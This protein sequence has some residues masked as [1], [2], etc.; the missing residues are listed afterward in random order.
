MSKAALVTAPQARIRRTQQERSAAMRLRLLDA[1]VDCLHDLGYSGTT[2]IEVAARAGVSRGAQLHHF[3][4]KERLVT[5]AVRHILAKRLQ[6][7]RDAFAS[8]PDGADKPGAALD[9]VWEKLSG[10][11]FYAWLELVVASRTDPALH[12]VVVEIAGQFLD[13]VQATARE[14]FESNDSGIFSLEIAP[15]FAFAAMQGLALDRIVWPADDGRLDR[16]LKALR[17]LATL[18]LRANDAPPSS[19]SERRPRK[20]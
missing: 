19:T 9:I 6:E 3:P 2:T 1:A 5:E 4:T 20:T 10:R 17:V 18:V 13:E 8:L 12:E 7:F 14:F 15:A 16:V 11:V